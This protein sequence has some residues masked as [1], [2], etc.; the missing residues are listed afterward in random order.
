MQVIM[1]SPKSSLEAEESGSISYTE[2]LSW[3]GRE[4]FRTHR[5]N[6]PNQESLRHAP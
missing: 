6:G 3:K 4:S 5:T 2:Y 1:L